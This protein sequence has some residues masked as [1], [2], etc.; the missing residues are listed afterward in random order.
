MDVMKAAGF[1]DDG[2]GNLTL[3]MAADMAMVTAAQ[4]AMEGYQAEVLARRAQGDNKARAAFLEEQ[5]ETKAEA[6]RRR[7][8]VQH[9]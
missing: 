1:T 8:E 2:E 6:D 5:A 9:C 7:A 3:D 4:A